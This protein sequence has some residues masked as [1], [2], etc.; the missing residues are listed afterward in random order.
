MYYSA[1]ERTRHNDGNNYGLADGH[2]N[3]MRDPD[4]GMWS[5]CAEDDI[6]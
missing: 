1:S 5:R 6:F 3:W 4:I 2:A